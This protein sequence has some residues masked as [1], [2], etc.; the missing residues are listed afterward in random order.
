LK[1]AGK[2]GA[3]G[4]YN[5]HHPT[6]SPLQGTVKLDCDTL[7]LGQIKDLFQSPKNFFRP[8]SKAV[9]QGIKTPLEML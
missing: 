5:L 9:F 7:G 1:K 4:R 6:Q 2:N 3:K 8:R